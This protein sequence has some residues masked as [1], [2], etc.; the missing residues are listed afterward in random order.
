[1]VSF[2]Y[3]ASLTFAA[4]FMSVHSDCSCGSFL[5]AVRPFNISMLM[6]HLC[7]PRYLVKM[8]LKGLFARWIQRRGVT[9]LVMFTN[10]LVSPMEL[11]H[12]KKSVNVS[13]LMISVWI[14]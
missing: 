11:N 8:S 3:F 6:S 2:K 1:M 10:L 9:P 4:F 12:W 13:F 7:V 5:F 14:A